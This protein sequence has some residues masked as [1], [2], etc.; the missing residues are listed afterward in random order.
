[1]FAGKWHAGEEEKY[2]PQYQGFDINIAGNKTGHPAGGYFSPYKNPQLEDGEDAEYLTDRLT[3]EVIH[4]IEQERQAPFFAYLS[5]YT[6]HLPLQGKPEK[7]DKYK[8]KLAL[9]TLQW[10]FGRTTFGS[11]SLGRL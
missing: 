3:D 9:S 2:Y 5:F 4:F 10:R 1:M 7:V 8:K 6:V 11:S